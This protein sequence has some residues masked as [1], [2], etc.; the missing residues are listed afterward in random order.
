MRLSDHSR[1]PGRYPGTLEKVL[2]GAA[3][4]L[5]LVAAFMFSL[6][7]LAVAVVV[8]LMVWGYFWWKTRKLREALREQARYGEGFQEGGFHRQPQG[9]ERGARSGDGQVIEG[10]AVVVDE[11]AEQRQSPSPP[12]QPR[13]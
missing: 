1:Q 12:H 3:G 10:E 7:I 4:A 8:G 6:M 9:P 2:T 11:A 5:L 13:P